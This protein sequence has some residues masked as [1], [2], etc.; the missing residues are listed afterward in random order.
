MDTSAS[1]HHGQHVLVWSHSCV[2]LQE[3]IRKSR[4]LLVFSRGLLQHLPF[5][6]SAVQFG[7]Y[8]C[9][10]SYLCQRTSVYLKVMQLFTANALPRLFTQRGYPVQLG[11]REYF[12]FLRRSCAGTYVSDKWYVLKSSWNVM[13]DFSRDLRSSYQASKAHEY[14]HQHLGTELFWLV[15][16]G[17]MVYESVSKVFYVFISFIVCSSRSLS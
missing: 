14:Q 10:Y 3:F 15:C 4:H 6:S 9:Q 1:E 12:L 13:V 17:S 7:V 5:S 16:R 11:S 8:I 2:Q